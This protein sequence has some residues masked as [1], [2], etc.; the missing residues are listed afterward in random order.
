[1]QKEKKM[2]VYLKIVIVDYKLCVVNT[3][4]KYFSVICNIACGNQWIPSDEYS[5]GCSIEN[6]FANLYHQRSGDN[7]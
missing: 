3:L 5:N 2:D 6:N 4:G 1:M 7:M